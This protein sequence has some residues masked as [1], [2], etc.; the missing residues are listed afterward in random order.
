MRD[1]PSK[2][3][4][5]FLGPL[6]PGAGLWAPNIK[7]PTARRVSLIVD[8]LTGLLQQGESLPI[9]EMRR[10]QPWLV[11]IEPESHIE[12]LVDLVSESVSKLNT[13]F[14]G[15]SFK[16]AT[17]LKALEY[18]GYHV[19]HEPLIP[20]IDV[21][22]IQADLARNLP[23]GDSA[24]L[25][26]ALVSRHILEHA[27]NPGEFLATCRKFVGASGYLI[28]EVPDAEPAIETLDFSELWDEHISYFTEQSL[29]IALE[30][31]G[32]SVLQ[33]K[34]IQSDGEDVLCAL[35]QPSENVLTSHKMTSPRTIAKTHRFLLGISSAPSFLARKFSELNVG[36]VVILGA[37]HRTSNLIDMF[38]PGSAEVQVIDD[39]VRK[40]GLTI[41]SRQIPVL[42]RQLCKSA[43]PQPDLVIVGLNKFKGREV[44]QS[45]ADLFIGD[46][47]TLTISDFYQHFGSQVSDT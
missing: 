44:L 37:N 27:S 10:T 40:Q 18:S 6:V 3:G 13:S 47:Q 45:L 26:T 38:L 12:S 25:S 23:S 4:E 28:V 17:T 19:H 42:S 7:P 33:L 15:L 32:F 1:V 22:L 30:S 21:P 43:Q 9:H 2:K 39:D 8:N 11:Q 31:S 20:G 35:A 5:V 24:G 41:S 46:P 14:C 29:R 16:D 36:S 34:K